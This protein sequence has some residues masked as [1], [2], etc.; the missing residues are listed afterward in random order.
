MFL[1]RAVGD[2]PPARRKDAEESRGG[3]DLE[4]EQSDRGT[5]RPENAGKEK[6]PRGRALSLLSRAILTMGCQ[7]GLM[8]LL[9]ADG[10]KGPLHPQRHRPSPRALVLSGDRPEP[11]AAAALPGEARAEAEKGAALAH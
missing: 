9:S 5:A 6:R 2:D 7:D 10:P 4:E 3:W 11:S 1:R 8:Y